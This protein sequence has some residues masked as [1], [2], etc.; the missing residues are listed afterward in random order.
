[1]LGASVASSQIIV[2]KMGRSTSECHNFSYT[3]SDWHDYYIVGKVC[4]CR[5]GRKFAMLNNQ[6][7]TPKKTSFDSSKR[8][9]NVSDLDFPNWISL[10]K[11][12]MWDDSSIFFHFERIEM[13]DKQYNDAS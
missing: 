2:V 9:Q 10:V 5:I 6:S 1:M 12:I 7:F 4:I 8:W 13:D 11:I 3:K